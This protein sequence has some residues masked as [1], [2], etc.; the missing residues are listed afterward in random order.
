VAGLRPALGCVLLGSALGVLTKT[1]VEVPVWTIL[2]APMAVGA[3][4][5]AAHRLRL[6]TSVATA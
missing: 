6:R 5:W 3:A 2:G 4:A 1:G